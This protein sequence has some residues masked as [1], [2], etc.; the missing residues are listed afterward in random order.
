MKKK[1]L[2]FITLF[3]LTSFVG[4]Q[5][6]ILWGMTSQG[7]AYGDG[8]IFKIDGSG[9]E[10]VMYSFGNGSADGAEPWGTLV[11]ATNGLYYGVTFVGGNSSLG[12]LFSYDISTNT[13]TVLHEFGGADGGLPCGSLIQASDSV[14]YGTT[15]FGGNNNEGAIFSYN[16]TTGA[17]TVLHDFGTGTDGQNPFSTLI[18]A[19]NGLLYGLTYQGGANNSGIIFSYSISTGA[20]T[21]VYD[22]KSTGDGRLPIYGPL[23][24]L[25]DS[26]LYGTTQ[27]GGA[28]SSGTIFNYNI[29][30]GVETDLYSFGNGTD[31]KTID[32][33]LFRASNGLLYGVSLY[34]GTNS[35]GVIY[36]YN[37]ATGTETVV[38]NFGNSSTDGG[39]GFGS[40]I[41]ACNG[42]LYGTTNEGGAYSNGILFSYNIATGTET[43]T[44]DFGSGTDGAAPHGN[45]LLEEDSSSPLSI[46][47][48][49]PSICSGASVSLTVS[50]GTTYSWAPS[51]T[52][53][54]STGDNVVATPTATTIYSV[55]SFNG[56]STS[57]DTVTIIA[58]PPLVVQPPSP[59][60]CPGQTVT[61]SVPVSGKG[62]SWSPSSTLSS[63]TAD[64]VI[65]TI[66]VTTTYTVTGT[67]SLGCF[68][69]GAD[70]VRVIPSPNK[71]SFTQHNDTLISSS[72]ND[73]QWYRNDTLLKNDTS[74]YLIITTLGDYW[75]MV[76]NEVNGCGTSSDTMT[77]SSLT[78][79]RQLTVDRGQLTVY[80]NPASNRL[81]V[82]SGQMTVNEITIINLLG[83]TVYKSLVTPKSPEGDLKKQTIDVSG[84][85]DGLYFIT[86]TTDTGTITQKFI[87]ERQEQ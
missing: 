28:Y 74:Q 2:F 45:D 47:P 46:I 8:T 23:I 14:L 53:N 67:D 61:L 76:T 49:S 75:V 29:L 41:Q 33:G 18:R 83:Q 39:I 82:E 48:Q 63:S 24:Q 66:S 35:A 87:K 86:V 10:T 25:N 32:G 9:A 38:H 59:S 50:G 6:P 22:F 69:S 58:A 64:S 51:T 30:S 60:V 13:E 19:T 4:A 16:I 34:G 37:I 80:P 1:L 7:G 5:N 52:L 3:S 44:H 31:G 78:G 72:E 36:S 15:W 11:K 71:P 85:P 56:C 21:D 54:D 65:A 77:I 68:A 40:I 73:N 17:E 26:L 84:L 42:L 27:F 20:E 55:T 81:T 62:Y 70:V 12:T 43:D 57:T 79:V